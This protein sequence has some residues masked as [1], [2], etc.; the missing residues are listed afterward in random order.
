MNN[1]ENIQKRNLLLVDD[2]EFIHKYFIY[3]LKDSNFTIYNAFSSSEAFRLLTQVPDISL[4]FMDIEMP[5]IN[6]EIAMK[7]IKHH[8]PRI[9]V[10]A[11]TSHILNGDRQK[12][13]SLGFDDY[14]D[15]PITR[16]KIFSTIQKYIK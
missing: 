12:L 9:K 5:G 10:I 6:G 7:E 8:Y 14:I 16:E 15:K 2:T 11:Q 1:Y 13:L 4:V 3:I